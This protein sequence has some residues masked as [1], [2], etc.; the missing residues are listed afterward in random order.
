MS[1]GE[2]REAPEQ[3]PRR[4]ELE[5]HCALKLD[6]AFNIPAQHDK[7]DLGVMGG[8]IRRGVAQDGSDGLKRCALPED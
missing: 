7:I 4:A 1:S 8:C 3:Y 2:G 6:V 5:A